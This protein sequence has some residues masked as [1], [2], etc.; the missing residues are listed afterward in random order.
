VRRDSDYY[1]AHIREVKSADDL[2]KN[3][4]L[5]TYAMTAFG[6]GDMIYAKAFMRKIL[7]EG[8]DDRSSFALQLADP[9]FRAFAETFNFSRHGAA[10]TAFDRAQQGTVERFVRVGLERDAGRADEGVRLALY[11]Q[12]RAPEVGSVYGLMSDAALYKV[13]RTA[14]GLP[15]ALSGV[16]IDRQASIIRG[17]IEIES[18]RSEAGLDR[19]LSRFTARWQMENGGA[20]LQVPQIGLGQPVLSSFANATMLMLQNLKRG[21]SA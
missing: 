7:T 1:L 8:I 18:L 12:R 4:R 9:R 3:D 17:R 15:A 19:F 11:F 5:F 10:T 13:V 20:A 16:D 21:G 14:L 2:L 6:L